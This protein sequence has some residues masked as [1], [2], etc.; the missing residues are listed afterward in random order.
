MDR[1][2]C[3]GRE[4]DISTCSFSGWGRTSCQHNQDV[5]ISC[6]AGNSEV[7]LVGGSRNEG[8]LEIMYSGT[9]RPVCKYYFSTSQARV[10]CR[11]LGLDDTNPIITSG[12]KYGAFSGSGYMVAMRSCPSNAVSPSQCSL[13]YGSPSYCRGARYGYPN[14]ETI[15]KCGQA[16][17][18]N[19]RLV[20]G[21]TQY[22]GAVEVFQNNQWGP[23]CDSNL[24]INLAKVICRSLGNTE[25][26]ADIFK[27]PKNHSNTRHYVMYNVRCGGTEKDVWSCRRSWNIRTCSEQSIIGVSCETR[28]RL[29][30]GTSFANGQLEV[31]YNGQWGTMC[32]DTFDKSEA[33][34]VCR[35]LG[36]E[37]KNAG[38]AKYG[39]SSTPLIKD[40]LHCSGTESD[41]SMCS[42]KGWNPSTCTN[43]HTVGVKCN[44]PVRLYG[45]R[46]PSVG[47]VELLIS[48]VWKRVCDHS[49]TKN[50]AVV[51]CHSLGYQNAAPEI[52]TMSSIDVGQD[53][54]AV[55]DIQCSGS[56][57]Y[58]A[59]CS[60]SNSQNT[61]CSP[62]NTVAISCTT[63]VKL[64]GG[65]YPNEGR[66]EIQHNGTWGSVC[67]HAFT[68]QD[69]R[70]VCS[71]LG[72]NNP[73]PE[74]CS[75]C[76]G[77]ANDNS[78]R[79]NVNCSNDES[80][81]SQCIDKWEDVSCLG[82]AGVRCSKC[83]Y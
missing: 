38:V 60:I 44:I 50:A 9:F 69:A 68:V 82:D 39:Y 61:T 15:L 17:A 35:M 65:R 6:D 73:Y 81:I 23:I 72:Y 41:I 33:N 66:I 51:I 18:S 29:L 21:S 49:F 59:D 45:G 30:G 76:F 19:V 11:L 25:E 16:P 2:G 26:Y 3:S 10:M 54:T 13:R 52:I 4:T 1:L 58:I 78:T 40:D 43:N 5:G 14:Y 80:D 63:N 42:Y 46:K 71:M 22:D 74:V 77:M 53:H 32:Y 34:V 79:Y 8:R 55:D 67:N 47:A 64:V 75:S 20:N 57:Q 36:F 83:Y 37:E 62:N 27:L 56:E 31:R 12:T 48:G 28:I 24:D 70:I 7:R